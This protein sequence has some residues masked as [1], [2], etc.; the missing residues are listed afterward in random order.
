MK[1][2]IERAM[3]IVALR[4]MVVMP[5]M[6]MHFDVSRKMSIAAVEQAMMSD[7]MLFVVAQKDENVERPTQDYLYHVGT[8]AMIKQ[9]IRMPGEVIRVMVIGIDRGQ[10]LEVSEGKK[11][12][13]GEVQTQDED[14]LE[15]LT[16]HEKTAMLENLKDDVKVYATEN[17]NVGQKAL[18]KVMSV[19]NIAKLIDEVLKI[20]PLQLEQKQQILSEF[21]LEKRYELVS[22]YLEE[23]IEIGRIRQD[24]QEKVKAKVDRGQREYLLR[25]QMR[26][27]REEL[28]EDSLSDAEEFL[29]RLEEL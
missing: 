28:G 13:V 7:Q 21:D 25:E 2:V 15:H 6:L 3:P 9:M 14:K 29:L 18:Q 17:G 23:D 5:G 20:F 10:L 24:F 19:Q 4:G 16:E 27:I 26:V 8:V 12:L 1:N 11:Y 22:A